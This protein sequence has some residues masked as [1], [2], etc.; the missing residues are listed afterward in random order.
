MR[1]M[2]MINSR[3]NTPDMSTQQQRMQQQASSYMYQNMPPPELGTINRQTYGDIS[4]IYYRHYLNGTYGTPEM[5]KELQSYMDTIRQQ[6]EATPRPTP[7]GTPVTSQYMG[8]G[9][10]G[11]PVAETTYQ[12]PQPSAPINTPQNRATLEARLRDM[13]AT[14]GQKGGRTVPTIGGPGGLPGMR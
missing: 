10:Q 7:Q 4:Q 8:M 2:T 1:L 12:Q 3:P 5:F 11:T 13:L 9:W 14:L 6:Q